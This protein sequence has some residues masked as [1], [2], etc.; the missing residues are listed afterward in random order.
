VAAGVVPIATGADGAGSLRIPAAFCGVIGFKGTYGRVP[1][2]AGRSRTQRIVAGVI[3]ARLGDV[4]LATSVASGP[5]PADPTALPHWPVPGP[6]DPGR[7]L[8]VAYSPG[9]GFAHPD[10]GVAEIVQQRVADLAGAGVIELADLTVQLADPEPSWLP[11]AELENGQLTDLA[12]LEHAFELRRRN[13]AALADAFA[14]IDVLV[15][16]TTPQTAFG[17]GDY[18]ANLPAGDLCWA[19]NL[20]GHPAVTVP[21]GLRQ[22]L[23]VG[24]QAVAAPHRDDLALAF[25]ELGQV[26]LPDPPVHW[27]TWRRAPHPA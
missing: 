24:L 16:P 2:A 12:R 17:I 9:L 26:R 15:T 3:G 20:S 5:H 21:A 22:G 25:A 8:R 23:P 10:P 19:F 18:E 1:R 7:R 4:V 11:L 27:G 14:M 13:D 6:A